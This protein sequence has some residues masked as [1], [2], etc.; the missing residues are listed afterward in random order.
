MSL[1]SMVRADW[2]LW[3]SPFEAVEVLDQ[4]QTVQDPAVPAMAIATGAIT[5]GQT[6]V[7][8]ERSLLRMDFRLDNAGD[9]RPGRIRLYRWRGSYHEKIEH[10]SL[11]E[12]VVD[13]SGAAGSRTHSFVPRLEV[14][15][16]STYY[17]EFG[18]DL[19]PTRLP[20]W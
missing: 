2:D 14:E 9:S 8:L 13:L 12:E 7:P 16:G 3:L 5:A 4:H 20:E 11:F 6:F 19:P 1:P 18:G 17:V 10:G 15:P